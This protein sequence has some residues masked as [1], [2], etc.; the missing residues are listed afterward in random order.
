M[1]LKKMGEDLKLSFNL[2]FHLSRHTFATNALSNGM[3]VEY[4]SKLLDHSSIQLTQV[5]AKIVSKELDNAV[6]KY[7]N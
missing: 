5:Y 3:R 6:D 2:H 1:H 4:M 7:I